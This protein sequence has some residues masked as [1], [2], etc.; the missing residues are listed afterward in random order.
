MTLSVVIIGRNEGARLDRCLQSVRAMHHETFDIEILYV[1]SVSTDDSIAIA[2][3]H[4]AEIVE[5][6]PSRPT[7][8]LGRNAGWR[9]ST[10]SFVL[11]LDGDTVL[12]PTFVDG[13]LTEFDQPKAAIV[14]GHRRE[15]HPEQS[16][17]NRVLDLDWI[18]APGVVEFCGGDAIV[19]RAVLEQV[20]GFDETLIAG[21]EPEMC[22]R[23]RAAGYQILHVDR[24]MT[25][26]DLAMTSWKQYCRRAMRAGY[27]YA[28]VS[29]RFRNTGMPFWEEDA[30]RNRSR[31]VILLLLPAVGAVTSI[32][33]WNAWPIAGSAAVLLLL[34]IRT[35][36]K[37]RWKSSDWGT[38]FLYGIHS[39]LQQIPIYWGQMQYA[40]DRR[41][42][43]RRGLI[44]YKDAAS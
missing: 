35:A 20:G 32:L 3:R 11:F 42:G 36:W 23:I 14:W 40:R 27:A 44:E 26:H 10:G 43:Q 16:I 28:E 7:A 31:A 18:Y 30:R 5:V 15:I 2:R 1:D 39:H 25:G 29:T 19:R 4:K 22:R 37:A 41:A 8:A 33:L 6:R 13:S 21:E 24:P 9:R 38:L 17:F 12:D 34:V